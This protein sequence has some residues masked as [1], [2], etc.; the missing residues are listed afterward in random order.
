M[1]HYIKIEWDNLGAPQMESRCTAL[2]GVTMCV[3]AINQFVRASKLSA[4]GKQQIKQA[5]LLEMEKQFKAG[6]DAQA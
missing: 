4:E 6:E 3:V 2:E 1:K 5:I